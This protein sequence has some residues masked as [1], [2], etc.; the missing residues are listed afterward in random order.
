MLCCQNWMPRGK[1]NWWDLLLFAIL[2]LVRCWGVRDCT[3]KALSINRCDTELGCFTL[4]HSIMDRIIIFFGV[5]FFPH[6]F[7]PFPN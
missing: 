1:F 4:T 6:S 5:S 2:R 7:L 3:Q